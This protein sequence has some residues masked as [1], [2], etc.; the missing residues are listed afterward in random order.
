MTDVVARVRIGAAVSTARLP[1]VIMVV[2][3]SVLVFSEPAGTS[4]WLGHFHDTGMYLSV[5]SFAVAGSFFA[6][7]GYHTGM[8][9]LSAVEVTRA[10]RPVGSAVGLRAAGDLTWLLGG[11][12][13]VHSAAYARTAWAAG[14]VEWHGWS[15]MVLGLASATLCY[16]GGLLLGRSVRHRLGLVVV[17]VVPYA[18]TLVSGEVALGPAWRF[19]QLMAPFIDQTWGTALLPRH[20][21]VLLLA[22]YA[23]LAAATLLAAVSR[24]TARS[25]DRAGLPIRVPLLATAAAAAVLVTSV[26]GSDYS[27]RRTDAVA[28]DPAGRVCMREVPGGSDLQDWVAAYDR[29][30]G[31]LGPSLRTELRFAESG[32]VLDGYTELP[33][34]PGRLTTST[35][36]RLMLDV[37]VRTMVDDACADDGEAVRVRAELVE[38]FGPRLETAGPPPSADEVGVVLGGC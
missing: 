29:L 8:R 38:M 10:G 15:L 6:L 20:P 19:H 16:A 4:R 9:A 13:V 11:L 7:S 22:L 18:L 1:A 30:G 5:L 36:A 32:V 35:L 27:V 25:A 34:P 21:A 17:A 14:A 12:L 28:C 2:V 23:A 37:A 31:A 3:G 24:L 26:Q 33:H